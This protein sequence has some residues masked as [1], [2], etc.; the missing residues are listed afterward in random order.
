[1]IGHIEIGDAIFST[2]MRD[3]RAFGWRSFKAPKGQRFV[4]LL[5]GTVD[6]EASNFDADAALNRLGW[7]FRDSDGSG[8]ASETQSGSTV[9]DSADPKGIAQ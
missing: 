5:L 6:K 8:E 1:M 7:H 9:G 4:L 3:E 2:T